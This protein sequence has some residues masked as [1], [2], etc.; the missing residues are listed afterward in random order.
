MSSKLNKK[1]PS[2]G[3]LNLVRPFMDKGEAVELASSLFGFRVTDLSQVKEFVSY[4]DRNFYMKGT[5]IDQNQGVAKEDEF[6]LKILNHLDSENLPFVNAQNEIMIHL[7]ASGFDCPI[8]I[9]SLNGAYTMVCKLKAFWNEDG[10]EDTNNELV[11][12]RV[13]AVRLLRF[14]PGKLLKDVS[15]TS[16]LLFDL[17]QYVARMH[18]V[19]QVNQ[20]LMLRNNVEQKSSSTDAVSVQFQLARSLTRR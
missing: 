4:D 14:V 6:V 9:R 19:L 13:H 1:R 8:P 7:K 12:S 3:S 20:K 15:C 18:K 17:G 5:F 16:D 10:T 2:D 11:T